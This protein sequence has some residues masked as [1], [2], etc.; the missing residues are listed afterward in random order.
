[1]ARTVADAAILLA[2][3]R[4]PIRA[5]RRRRRRARSATRTTPTGLDAEGAPRRA[6]RRAA[7][8]VLRLQPGGGRD[9]AARD[10]RHEAR[11][12]PSI[13]D[14]VPIANDGR[15]GD[16]EFEVLLYEFKA[17]LNDYLASLGAGAQMRTLTDLIAFNEAHKSDGDAV[18]RAGDL[19]AG[20]EAA[21]SPMRS[22]R[23]RSRSAA[24]HARARGSTRS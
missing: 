10:R 24:R 16:A 5:T 7:R 3:S 1:M 17:G 23:R 8:A 4:A 14:P 22:T 15:L 21:R 19:R 6:H 9:R 12:A 13:V 18:L 20:A 2:R 11:R